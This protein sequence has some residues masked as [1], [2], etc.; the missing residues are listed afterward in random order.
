MKRLKDAERGSVKQEASASLRI[1]LVYPNS[2]EV[3]MAS[4]G[5]QTVYREFNAISGVR[6]ERFF[7]FQ[8]PYDN[9]MRSL[10]SFEQL[11]K[12]DVIAFS[13][14]FELDMLNVLRVLHLGGIPLKSSDRSDKDPIVIL[15]GVIAS[16]NPSPLLNY[17]D[18]L[19][20][21]EGEDHFS[22]LIDCIRSASNYGRW[23]NS[24]KEQLAALPGF[25]VPGISTPV[26]RNVI[27]NLNDHQVYTP[28]ITPFS[29][30][31]DLFVVEIGRGCGRGCFF[32]AAQKV[33]APIRVRSR[34]AILKTIKDHNPGAER[35]GLE[36]AGLSDYPELVDLCSDILD[37]RLKISFSS[38]RA[39]KVDVELIKI[40]DKSG[41][42]S[43]TI[44]PEAGTERMRQKIGK[45]I[46][47][48]QILNTVSLLARTNIRIIKLYYLIGLPGETEQDIDA[49]VQ[50]C[51]EI[52]QILKFSSSAKQIK[53]SVN[54]FI[55]KPFTEF[56]WAP[57]ASYS[58]INKMHKRLERE[59]HR[60][61]GQ[62]V[63]SKCSRYSIWQSMLAM[64]DIDI[65]SQMAAGVTA[66]MS[67]Q[68][69]YKDI[70]KNNKSL[71]GGYKDSS[72]IFPW[73]SVQYTAN[74]HI[75]WRR[76]LHYTDS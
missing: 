22:K 48:E 53:I 9:E 33:Y 41:A 65:G 56:Q 67:T 37:M 24:V 27:Q 42:R 17:L 49:I 8:P 38:I 5:F 72:F 6:C 16:L 4:M 19:L 32:C 28:I 14:S 71:I 50:L 29:H 74:Q 35:I 23:R 59:L 76:Y 51:K 39:D 60:P 68:E 20:I 36:S 75:L 45:G 52:E 62:A 12:F 2:Y 46:S 54:P 66:N 31:S 55:P 61:P 21:G 25:F 63:V 40:L 15:G 43:F 13:L 64:G 11:N 18:G 73:T 26:M 30:F 1:A 57:M 3:G 7:L 34:E 58:W 70:L 47:D 44:A 10:E 69:I